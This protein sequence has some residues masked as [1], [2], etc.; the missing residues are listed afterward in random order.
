[1]HAFRTSI[2]DNEI[3]KTAC[4]GR[5]LVA[6]LELKWKPWSANKCSE[7]YVSVENSG[8]R[9]SRSKICKSYMFI[10]MCLLFT[11]FP[12]LEVVYDVRNILIYKVSVLWVQVF[13]DN[14]D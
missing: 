12:T 4:K 5:M 9:N 7:K 8:R 14:A 1:M 13:S 11:E 10:T 2:K 6:V 3:T